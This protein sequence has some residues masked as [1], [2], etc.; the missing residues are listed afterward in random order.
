MSEEEFGL[1]C[2]DTSASFTDSNFQP[3][4]GKGKSSPGMNLAIIQKYY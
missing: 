3:F 4:R 1:M 2:E